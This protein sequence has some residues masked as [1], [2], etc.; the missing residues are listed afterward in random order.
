MTNNDLEHQVHVALDQ[1]LAIVMGGGA[2]TRLFPLTKDRSKPAVPLAGKYRLVDIPI[3]NCIN[4]SVRS[5]YV[6]TQF[7]SASLHRHISSAY[8]FDR[9]S[10]SFV[11]ILAAQQTPGSQAWYQGTADAVRQNLRYFTSGRYKYYL[12][13]SGDQLYSMDFRKIMR[14]HLKSQAELTIAT[15]PVEREPAKSFGIMLTTDDGDI[16]RFEEKPSD[17]AILDELKMSP[18]RLKEN[19]LPEDS[20]HYLASMGIY[21]FNRDAMLD[22]LDNDKIDFGKDV[23]PTTIT[24]KKVFSYIFQGYWE[25]IGTI[26]SFFDANLDLTENVPAYNFFDYLHPIYTHARFLPASK[27]NNAEIN[28]AVI[29]DGCIVTKAKISRCVIGIRSFIDEGSEISNTIIMGADHFDDRAKATENNVPALGIGRDCKIDHTIIDKNARI[30]DRVHISPEGKPETFDG[31][32]F[33]IRDG[34]VVIP[35][36]AVIPSDTWI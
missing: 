28:K 20:E 12:I 25:D 34:I 1:T 23:I 32:N 5:I 27:I 10:D 35:K 14:E 18:Q 15:L 4:S 9:F 19:N 6:L 2:G 22:A 26:R 30:G 11:E 7:N 24:R 16:T 33:F 31:E 21:L 13:L 17:P 8:K 3:S 36:G 29:S